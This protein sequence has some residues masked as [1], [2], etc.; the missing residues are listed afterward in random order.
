LTVLEGLMRMVEQGEASRDQ[1]I[2]LTDGKADS[3]MGFVREVKQ[4]ADVLRF[5]LP[6]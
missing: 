5:R 2:L 1:M 6:A 3:R 4:L